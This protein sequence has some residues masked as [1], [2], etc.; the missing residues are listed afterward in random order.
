[1]WE[2][3]YGVSTY[4]FHYLYHNREDVKQESVLRA[5]VSLLARE[6]QQ[7]PRQGS[8]RHLELHKITKQK[9]HIKPR[10]YIVFERFVAFRNKN[11]IK[12]IDGGEPYA[13]ERRRCIAYDSHKRVF[14][15]H[16]RCWCGRVEVISL[17]WKETSRVSSI[18]I[19]MVLNKCKLPFECGFLRRGG[20]LPADLGGFVTEE[21]AEGLLPWVFQEKKN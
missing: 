18:K 6:K 19:Q 17:N 10:K 12:I 8:C 5:E 14:T 1:M 3:D 13:I 2:Y 7:Q 15:S 21:C 11:E 16:G 4:I 20:R 9:P